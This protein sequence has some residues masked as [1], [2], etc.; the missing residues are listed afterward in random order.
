MFVG[1]KR[2]LKQLEEAYCSKKSE[3]VAI[4]GRRRIGKSALINRFSEAKHNRLHFEAIEGGDTKAQIE[5][6]KA[7][8]ATA[9]QDR[10]INNMSFTSWHELF[11][12]FTEKFVD[13]K[14]HDTKLIIS[15][16]E[17]QWM[18]LQKSQ[19]ISVIKYFWDTHWKQNNIMLI[20]CGSIASFM[21][22]KVLKS[23][24]LYGRLSLELMLDGLKPQEAIKF[25]NARRGNEEILKYLLVFGGVPKYFEEINMNKSFNQNLNRLCFAKNALM[26][27]EIDRM[28]YSQFREAGTYLRIVRLL[29]EGL[30]TLKEIGEKLRISSGGSLRTYLQNLENANMVRQYIPFNKSLNTKTKKYTLSD[31]YLRFYFKFIE[32]NMSA[33]QL[34]ES[35]HFF[36]TVCENQFKIWS[37]FAFERFCIKNNHLLAE[38]MGFS[39]NIIRASPYFGKNDSKFQIDLLYLRSDKVITLCEIKYYDTAVGTKVIPEIEKKA[40][41]LKI[42][43]GYTIEK[44]LISL[45]GSDK[46]LKDSCYLHHDITLSQIL[47]GSS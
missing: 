35:E 44:A 23:K 24:A 47:T 17:I 38:V 37:G 7:T 43:N 10:F 30:F 36:E 1:R 39:K 4:Y 16:D 15:F 2:E 46:S 19:L 45:H 25:F 9:T 32:P 14:N 34:N 18:A 33:I 8:L 21:V 40:S 13:K 42:P 26:L 28:F 20:L 6:F 3:L 29:K 41:L 12:F 5:H 22:N 31:E 27:H 11:D